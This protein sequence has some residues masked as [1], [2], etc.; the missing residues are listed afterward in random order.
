MTDH[1]K[2]RQPD[3]IEG[4]GEVVHDDD[5]AVDEKLPVELTVL[6]RVAETFV[7]ADSAVI[8]FGEIGNHG[9]AEFLRGFRQTRYITEDQD[10]R[11]SAGTDP[12]RDRIPLM[13]IR[14]AREGFE[15]RHDRE[16]VFV[17]C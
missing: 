9:E 1:H 16:H 17:T 6:L 10:L 8:A 12:A 7:D 2:L 5:V 14:G 13:N 4:G 3:R 11:V 15:R